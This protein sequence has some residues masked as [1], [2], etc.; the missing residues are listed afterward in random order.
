[1][2]DSEVIDYIPVKY[3]VNSTY[4]ANTAFIPTKFDVNVKKDKANISIEVLDFKH[5]S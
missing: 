1:M 2:Y 5:S 3:I 4:D